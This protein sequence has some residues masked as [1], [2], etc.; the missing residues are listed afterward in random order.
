MGPC[1]IRA[2]PRL[3]RLNVISAS[4]EEIEVVAKVKVPIDFEVQY[5]DTS[6]AWWDSE[7]KEFIGGEKEVQALELEMTLSVLIII[8]PQDESITEVD[9]LTRDVYVQEPYETF[10]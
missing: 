6:S 7:D 9:L 10:K 5:L 8:D 1:L 4:D 2:H 3:D